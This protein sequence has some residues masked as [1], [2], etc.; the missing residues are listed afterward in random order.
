MF[1]PAAAEEE[2]ETGV[3]S[4]EDTSVSINTLLSQSYT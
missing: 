1:Q 4:A 2:E 3:R